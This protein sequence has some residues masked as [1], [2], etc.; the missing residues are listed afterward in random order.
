MKVPAFVRRADPRVVFGG[1]GPGQLATYRLHLLSSLAAAAVSGV[2]LNSEYITANGLHATAWQITLLVMIWPMS[3][4]L[5]V[6]VN[7]IIERSGRFER[8]VI[9]AGLLRLPVA[10]MYFSRSASVLLVLLGLYSAADSVL[11]PVLNNILREKYSEGRRG[12]LLGWAV[13]FFTLFSVPA[14][15]L[16]GRLLDADF[17]VYRILFVCMAASGFAHA[18]IFSRMARGLRSYWEPGREGVLRRLVRVFSRDRRFALFEAYFMIYGF[19]FMM[20][21]PAIPLFARDCLGLR[22]EQYALAKGLVAQVG[23]LLLSP[24]MGVRVERWH[25]FRFTGM[26]CLVLSLYPLGLALS[27][28]LPGA[29]VVM[30]FGA[31][32]VY[33]VAMA[34]INISWNMSSLHFAPEGQAATYQGLHLTLTAARGLVAPLLGNAIMQISGYRSTFLASAGL[35]ALAGLLYLRRYRSGGKADDE[36]YGRTEP[37]ACPA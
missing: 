25:P 6:F 32:A 31:F 16:V 14:A 1:L 5:S 35:F 2:M 27:G 30:F 4:S 17:G 10:L 7:T 22:Y 33:S 18:M 12:F 24:F 15:I 36:R 13:S 20:V 28:L 34:G 9:L 26:V 11:V 19:A 37:A 29:G 3:N 8:A 21:L 23:I